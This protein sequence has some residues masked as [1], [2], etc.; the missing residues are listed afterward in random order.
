MTAP[1][2]DAPEPEEWVQ[3]DR[4]IRERQKAWDGKEG[5]W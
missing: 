3:E 5:Q 4:I 2:L 1:E